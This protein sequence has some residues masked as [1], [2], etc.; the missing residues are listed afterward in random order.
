MR[1]LICELLNK[2]ERLSSPTS[3]LSIY[4]HNVKIVTVN[5]AVTLNGTVRSAA[6]QSNIVAKAKAVAGDHERGRMK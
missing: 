3:P 1:P 4:G 6:E 2:S 5:G